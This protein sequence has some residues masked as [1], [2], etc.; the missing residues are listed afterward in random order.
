MT[1]D[2]SLTL[3][4]KFATD[5]AG[6]ELPEK[7]KEKARHKLIQSELSNSELDVLWHT[8]CSLYEMAENFE[9]TIQNN[10]R[11]LDNE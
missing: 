11:T 5:N 1:R 10:I 6:S 4:Q 7:F 9:E 2:I 3:L 8:L